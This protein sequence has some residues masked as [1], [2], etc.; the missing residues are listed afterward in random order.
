VASKAAR[1]VA[2][3]DAVVVDGPP[4][5]FVS[6]GGDKLAA[7]LERFGVD[8]KGRAALDVGASTGGFT[9]CLLQAGAARVVA[10]D[11][12]RNQLHERLRDDARVHSVEGFNARHMKPDDVGGRFPVVVGDV[13]FISL[14][15][16][17]DAVFAC[18]TDDA[19]V[20]LL[21][22]PQFEAGRAEVARGRG[23]VRD[24]RV[25]Q[26]VLE[27]LDA[28]WTPRAAAM[29]DL[30]V[31]PLTGTGGNVEFL[32]HLRHGA[33]PANAPS[34]APARIAAAIVDALALVDNAGDR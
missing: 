29:M 13:S 6:R 33:A 4:P 7:A 8:V 11:V 15:A 2:T 20:I 3:A 5:R 26:E 25:W 9:D 27:R 21:V 34:N 31:S 16:V 23:I 32:V 1:L 17:L 30:M 14:D 19:D 24:P 28:A 22:K 10:V 18:A 12:G